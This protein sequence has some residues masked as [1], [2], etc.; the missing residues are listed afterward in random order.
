M[1][2]PADDPVLVL[3]AGSMSGD[4]SSGT[5]PWGGVGVTSGDA[6]VFEILDGDGLPGVLQ[7]PDQEPRL[8]GIVWGSQRIRVNQRTFGVGVGGV[9]CRLTSKDGHNGMVTQTAPK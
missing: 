2:R 4:V 9:G 7:C 5:D 8:I 1:Q 3:F 6:P